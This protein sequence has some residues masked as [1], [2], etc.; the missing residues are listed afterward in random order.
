MKKISKILI[1]FI[2]ATML[3]V[4]C[5]SKD[6]QNTNIEEIALDEAKKITS[7]QGYT[8]KT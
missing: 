5:G 2:T 6:I 3:L 4:G 7:E 8:L 1:T